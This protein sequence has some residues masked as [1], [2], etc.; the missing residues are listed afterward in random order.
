MDRGYRSEIVWCIWD[1][2]RVGYRVYIWDCQ[3]S[4]ALNTFITKL[5][6]V[7]VDWEQ[8]QWAIG[9]GG[10]QPGWTYWWSICAVNEGLQ[11]NFAPGGLFGGF[12]VQSAPRSR[13]WWGVY[14]FTA[15]I[16]L[17]WE[18]PDTKQ[19]QPPPP[20]TATE[21]RRGIIIIPLL[22]I[23]T[24]VSPLWNQNCLFHHLDSRDLNHTC[25]LKN[26]S[27]TQ[28]EGFIF[29]W[30]LAWFV[31]PMCWNFACLQMSTLCLFA[32]YC[33]SIFNMFRARMCA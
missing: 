30:S 31:Q 9:I 25:R 32:S 2:Y 22:S 26:T 18:F 24:F 17:R 14:N 3:A 16:C 29:P 4:W 28:K 23:S 1:R 6:K 11:A 5:V 10:L 19:H 20:A 33:W 12:S 27:Q 8:S 15:W 21:T 7:Y 13:W